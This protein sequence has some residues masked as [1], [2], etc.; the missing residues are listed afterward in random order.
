M[1][2]QQSRKVEVLRWRCMHTYYLGI[3]N[4]CRMPKLGDHL[5]GHMV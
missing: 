4:G 5:P 1:T 2:S 3:I